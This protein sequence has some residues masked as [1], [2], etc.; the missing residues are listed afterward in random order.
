L[1]LDV[2]SRE[3]VQSR[4]ASEPLARGLLDVLAMSALLALVLGVA[5]LVLVCAADL[6]DERD[7]LVDLEAMGVG[8]PALRRHLVLR[9]AALVVTGIAGGLVLGAILERLV[10]D[11]VSLGGGAATAEPPLRGVQDWATVAAGLAAFAACGVALVWAFARTAFRA[12]V[13]GRIGGGP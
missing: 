1:V 2:H 11:L 7:H 9:A 4:L 12:A 3:D 5:G 6:G 10:I 8:P 13:P